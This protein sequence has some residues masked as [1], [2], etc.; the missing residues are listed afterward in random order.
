M[1]GNAFENFLA[2]FGLGAE[3]QEPTI[4]PPPPA[5]DEDEVRRRQFA[6][7]A[8]RY[9]SEGPEAIAKRKSEEYFG[10]GKRKVGLK[11]LDILGALGGSGGADRMF[12]RQA[13]EE[14][15][16][17]APVLQR[18]LA[19]EEMQQ[20]RKAAAEQRAESEKARLEAT[21]EN[22]EAKLTL[23]YA[24]LA[25]KGALTDADRNR[26][27]A[28]AR[29]LNATAKL[30]ELDAQYLEKTGARPGTMP[31]QILAAQ[32]VANDPSLLEGIFKIGA[33]GQGGRSLAS[34]MAGL[35]PGGRGGTTVSVSTSNPL[36]PDPNDPSRMIRGPEQTTRRV[37]TRGGGGETPSPEQYQR[38]IFGVLR[39]ATPLSPASPE[40]QAQAAA[41]GQAASQ[42]TG[43]KVAPK[44]P[45]QHVPGPPKPPVG[46]AAVRPAP[47]PL[48]KPTTATSA[49]TPDGTL[50]PDKVSDP[51]ELVF[52]RPGPE[53]VMT[54]NP[55]K[56]F[57][58]RRNIVNDALNRYATVMA[59]MGNN[60]ELINT[61]GPVAGHPIM[62]ALKNIT[63]KQTTAQTLVGEE[64]IRNYAKELFALSGKQVNQTE[65][66]YL[67]EFV[68]RMQDSP[69]VFLRKVIFNR[70]LA[71]RQA[72]LEGFDR[73]TNRPVRNNLRSGQYFSFE[74]LGAKARQLEQ[75]YMAGQN[76]TPEDFDM[77]RVY[78]AS[79]RR[80]QDR[81][82]KREITVRA[83]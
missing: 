22:N 24:K 30:K 37:S 26:L 72:F 69:N 49:Y 32:Q 75:K 77:D 54:K 39:G 5:M 33:A 66:R 80:V 16:A 44:L 3:S 7:E 2:Q 43:K 68:P 18:D 14:Y 12:H 27:D 38:D 6:D 21:R 63:G 62:R 46:A 15:K 64:T 41:A 29:S 56:E 73:Y 11:I 42:Q 47:A 76:L 36:V 59:V 28:M 13:L 70:L 51:R 20:A 58:D 45:V 9:I 53:T 35:G 57:V 23:E 61:V 67:Q 65:Q 79:L 31:S 71:E 4:A 1:N 55:P 52:A 19:A 17:K 74:T 83:R 60:R 25:Q 78:S 10:K 48:G 81:I 8:L 34:L 40:A 82:K 50:D